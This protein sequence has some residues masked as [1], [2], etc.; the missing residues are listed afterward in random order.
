MLFVKGVRVW[1]EFNNFMGVLSSGGVL[2]IF[3]SVNSG[4]PLLE[5][6]GFHTRLVFSYWTVYILLVFFGDRIVYIL[7]FFWR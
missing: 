3:V 2:S 7:L 4:T 1:S 6:T 5:T